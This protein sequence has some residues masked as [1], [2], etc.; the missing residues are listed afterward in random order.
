MY[1][2]LVF[3]H[4]IGLVLFVAMH[5]VAMFMAF[6]VR[7]EREPATAKVLLAMSSRAN[8]VMYLGLL[9]LGIGGL[10]AAGSAGLLVAPWVVASYVVLIVVFIAMYALG[11]GFYYPLREALEGKEGAPPLDSA[12]MVARLQNRRP[13]ALSLFGFWKFYVVEAQSDIDARQTRLTALRGDI[14]K[15]VAT[16][17]RLPQFQSEVAE[18]E[19][20]LDNLR[21]VLPE[22]KDVADILR[23][24]QGLATQSS[25]NLQRF[26]PLE[27][28]QESI[29]ASLPFRLRAEGT[30]HNLGQFFDRIGKFPRIINV[31]ELTIKPRQPQ[32]PDMSIEAEFVATTFVLQESKAPA[33]G[34]R[35]RIVPKPPAATK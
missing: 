10:G 4:L 3:V 32:E 26:T 19:R 30:F 20:K 27:P 15:G 12:A 6:R 5:G 35:G 21:A 29:Y 14:A 8:Q 31:G 11:A 17:R 7:T 34:G 2:W 25:L 9:L 13:E 28:K 22:Q 1:Q 23:R 24:V 16:A 18:L 33:T